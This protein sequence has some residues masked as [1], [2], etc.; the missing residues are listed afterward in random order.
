M[1]PIRPFFL[2]LLL[3][4]LLLIVNRNDGHLIP[5]KINVSGG[6]R[7][8]GLTENLVSCGDSFCDLQFCKEAN[9]K[10]GFECRTD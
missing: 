1:T 2:P 8:N 10:G 6:V 7:E 9:E 5:P 3:L 4:L